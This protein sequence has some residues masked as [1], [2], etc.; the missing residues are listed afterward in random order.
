MENEVN[1]FNDINQTQDYNEKK[2]P[3]INNVD[4][5][6]KNDIPEN[7]PLINNENNKDNDN[8]ENN[9]DN[10]NIENNKDNDNI[11][12]NKDNDNI[13]NGKDSDNIDNNKDNDNIENNKDNDNIDNNKDNDN[14]ENNNIVL[15]SKKEENEKE[16]KNNIIND[17]MKEER[18]ETKDDILEND[19]IKDESMNSL[20]NINNSHLRIN[21][22][23]ELDKIIAGKDESQLINQNNINDNLEFKIDERNS[24]NDEDLEEGQ[25]LN[26]NN[27]LGNIFRDVA[28]KKRNLRTESRMSIFHN[29]D[30]EKE[31]V[32]FGEI[33]NAQ[34]NQLKDKTLSY[35]DKI[36]KEFEKRYTDYINKM[37]TYINENELKI[38][39]VLQKDIEN[40]ENILEFAD[41]NIFKKFDNIFEIHENIFSAIEDHVG[42]LR[43]FLRQTDLIQQKNPLEIFINNNSNDILKCWFLNKIDY[44]KL[45]LSTV[46]I[47]KDLSELCSRYLIKKKDNKFSSITIKKDTKGNLSLESDFVRENIDNLEKLKVMNLKSEEINLIFKNKNN[48]N[49]KD[50]QN[51]N[52]GDNEII[53]SAKKLRSLSIIESDFSSINLTKISTPEL[54]KLKLKRTPLALSLRYFFDS[55]LGNSLFLQNLYLQK[56]F[57]DDQSLSQIF[58]FLS[59]KPQIVE[60]LQNISFCGNEI[61]SVDMKILI[62]K[63]CNFKSLQYLDFSKNNIYEFL[64]DNFKCF[65]KLN[66]L[67]LTDNNISNYIFFQAIN[68]QKKEIQSI[69]LLC[70]NMFLNNNRTNSNKYREY[71]DQNLGKFKYKIKKLNFSFLYTKDTINHLLA[72]RISSMVK[73][74]LIKL[75]LSY[76][77]LCNGDV[78]NFLQNNFGLLN[79]K[80][81]NLSNNFITVKIFNLIL[82]I[83]LSLEKLA[84]LDLSMNNIDSLTIEEYTDIEK[85]I[86]KHPKLKKIK[87][88]DSTFCQDLLLLTQMEKEKCDKINKNLISKEVKF[89]VEKEYNILIVPLKDLFELKDKEI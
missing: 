12:N 76:C 31:N 9:K 69:V 79:L 5:N 10:D 85:F 17:D 56:C 81:L 59:E 48:K 54:K 42:L 62:D 37:T 77:G 65:Q 55:V 84:S 13:E 43:V 74:S 32:N 67:D 4:E 16:N 66:V 58:L 63:N 60:S 89:F 82:K 49:N 29:F 87:F 52:Q 72:L 1:D 68:A 51:N 11:E 39:K 35:F 80:D 61:T 41:N 38:S 64:T 20:Q 34:L 21:S 6:E 27:Y 36:I 78:C 24:E 70:N 44:Q 75:N 47:N 14:N 46:I 50:I 53:P 7:K 57:L 8:I 23:L 3:D 73:I 88:Q 2:I 19:L 45:N 26:V 30:E 40:D 25:N 22:E 18:S 71:L 28:N 33:I 15:D 83:D 86:I